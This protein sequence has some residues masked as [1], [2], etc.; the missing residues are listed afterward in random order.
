MCLFQGQAM[1]FCAGGDVHVSNSTWGDCGAAGRRAKTESHAATQPHA[2]SRASDRDQEPGAIVHAFA[3][4]RR[5]LYSSGTHT[6]ARN[7]A[8]LA[9]L[10]SSKNPGDQPFFHNPSIAIP[11]PPFQGTDC[12]PAAQLLARI[13]R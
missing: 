6:P 11:N 12:Q 3:F 7:L 5:L 4:L 2:P 8:S 9:R 10:R 13:A 1:S